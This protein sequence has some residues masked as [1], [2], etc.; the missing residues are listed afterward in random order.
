MVIVPIGFLSDHVEILF[1]LDTEARQL[2]QERG[3]NMVR[4]R[5]V[6]THPDFVKMIRELIV[7]RMS[8]APD[9]PALGQLGPSHDG[10]P[11]TCCPSGRPP[12]AK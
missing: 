3:L 8:A 5:T 1:D 6:G 7:E 9:R 2:C 11:E 12:A 10:C 4:S